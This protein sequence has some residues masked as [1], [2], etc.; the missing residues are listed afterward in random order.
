MNFL[1]LDIGTSAVKGVILCDGAVLAEGER[2]LTTDRPGP[3]RSEQDP[4]HWVAAVEELLDAIAAQAPAALA[5]VKGIGLAGQMH[6]LVCLGADH[7]P[8]R[9]AILWNDGRAAAEATWLNRTHPDLARIAGVPAAPGFAAVTALWL[10]RHE[11]ATWAATRGLCLPKDYVRLHL[12]GDLATDMSDAGGSWWLDEAKR[13]W[14]HQALA[15]TGVS[16]DRLP[17]LVE[18]TAPTG[19]L[20]PALARRWGMADGVVIAGGAGDACAGAVGIGAISRGAFLS[21][22]TSAQ[23]LTPGTHYRPLPERFLHAYCHCVP[24]RWVQ[25]AALLN[26]ASCLSWLANGTG[27]GIET[28]LA[29]AEAA[30]DRRASPIF[31]PYLSGER[32]P[33]N[34][35]LA[36]GAFIGLTPSTSRGDLA[37]GVMEGV[38]Y[39]MADAADCLKAAGAEIAGAGVIG[40]GAR[41]TFWVQILADVLGEPLTRYRGGAKGPAFGAAC[42]GRVAT[43]GEDIA[44]VATVPPVEDV[45]APRPDRTAAHAGRLETFRQLYQALKS[46]RP[47]AEA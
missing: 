20:R 45:V 9:P 22:G 40:G 17:R 42:L 1:G 38:A 24:D 12:S 13:A 23:I 2:P 11:P 30:E 5:G 19:H 3:G 16:P 21:L 28:L 35:P 47:I 26:G 7:R 8:L 18:G 10:A 4:A 37:L 32:T 34:D 25:V 41:S 31:L 46:V 44:E 6:G 27:A 43:T 36:T 29:E 33:H 14:S 39:A 15:A